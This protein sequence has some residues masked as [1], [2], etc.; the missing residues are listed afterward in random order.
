[1]K[2]KRDAARRRARERAVTASPLGGT[3][4]YEPRVTG[5]VRGQNDPTLSEAG[6][7]ELQ[8][9]LDDEVHRLPEKL[10][11]PFVLCCL[12]GKSTAEAAHLLR[13][14][15]GTVSGRLSLARKEL[16]RRLTRR[17]LMLSAALCVL[18]ISRTATASSV[19]AGLTSATVRAAL[20]HCG[21]QAAAAALGGTGVPPV[22]PRVAALA[23]GVTKTMML[24]TP[25]IVTAGLI[26]LTAGLAGAGLVIHQALAERPLQ[27]NSVTRP[28]EKRAQQ[29]PAKT[30]TPKPAAPARADEQDAT[31]TVTFSGRV[32]DPDGKPVKD[33]K[34]FI[35]IH[36]PTKRSL[37]MRGTSAE[38]GKYRFT[39][40]KAEFDSTY[41]PE[42][43]KYTLV[44]AM[45]N[46]YGLGLPQIDYDKPIEPRAT[47]DL[48]IHLAKDDVVITG[49]VLD[50]Q[51]KPIAGIRI[52]VRGIQG[53]RKGDLTS[54][55]SALK[56]RKEGFYPQ[57]E[58][59]MGIRDPYHGWDLDRMYPPVVTDADGRFRIKGV[60]RE[61]VADL[62]I[63]GP[64]IETK[65]VYVVTRPSETIDVPYLKDQL[66]PAL[67]SQYTHYGST[68]EHVA[69]PSKPVIGVVRDKDTGKPIPGAVIRSYR[70]A[71]N[72][73]DDRVSFRVVA[74]HTARATRCKRGDR[75]MERPT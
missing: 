3:A 52:R 46:G 41:S 15:V 24:S 56:T 25:K 39:V 27:D 34:L 68:F 32:L 22:L 45:A 21:G 29:P 54:F 72:R 40:P 2:A 49:R 35:L 9:V 13:W 70:L 48:T 19:P 11:A 66:Y 55:I 61:R 14:K 12:E 60:G 36:N 50:L 5:R 74:D 43:W 62:L 47:D 69:P 28:P 59:L 33:A 63:E 53:P 17:G 42:P 4:G 10:R 1:M 23:Q 7:R 64:T 18:G 57:Q 67:A 44:L 51:A 30:T 26:I 73:F 37:T 71:E 16:Q 31:Q 20:A 65:Y 8:A 75:L 38:D 58:L 6:L